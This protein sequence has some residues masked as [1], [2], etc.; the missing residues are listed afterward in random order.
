MDLRVWREK[1]E[2]TLRAL[3][4]ESGV[5]LATLVRLEAGTFDP[6]LST[7]RKLANAL[8]VSVCVLLGEEPKKGRG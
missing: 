1:R 4:K 6:R 5:G 7:L 2:K 8:N 3:A